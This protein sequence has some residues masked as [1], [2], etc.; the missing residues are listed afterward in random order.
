MPTTNA[1]TDAT[2]QNVGFDCFEADLQS[3]LLFKRGLKIPLREQ[4]FQVLACLLQHPAQVVSREELRRQLWPGDVFVDFEKSL[5]TAVAHLRQ[6]L[7]DSADRPRFIETVPKRGYRFLAGVR[8]LPENA[9]GPI[10]RRTR[11][12]VLPF[13]NWSG[14]AAEEYFSDAMTDE[15]ITALAALAPERLAVI[16]R[17]TAMRYKGTHKD[18]ARIGRELNVDYVV[19]GGVRRA[20]HRVAIN[21]QL[22]R[23]SDQTHVFA[24]KYDAEM[25][26]VFGLHDRVARDIGTQIPAAAG[27][28]PNDATLRGRARKPTEDLAAYNEYIQGRYFMSRWTPE[29]VAKARRHFEVALA[30]DPAF[31]LAYDAL[32]E[33]CW[34]LG[35]WGFASPTEMDLIGRGYALRAIEIDDTLAETHALLGYFPKAGYWDWEEVLQCV[36]RGRGLNPASPVVGLRYAIAL[37]VVGRAG[38]A[39]TELERALESDPL[40]LELRGWFAEA[41]YLGRQYDRA[42]EQALLLAESEPQHFLSHMVLGHVYLG[43]QRY[44]ESVA[45]LRKSADVSGGFPLVLGW[46]GL[47]LGL[48]GHSE[49]A[50]TVLERLRA[51]AKQSYVPPTS[52]AWTHLGLG[53]IDDALIWLDR[54]ADAHDRMANTLKTYPFLDPLRADP[55]FHALLRKMN[56]ES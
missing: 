4:S 30:R 19:E 5:N 11:L 46:L 10:T 24:R 49:E 48:G 14:D 9:T 32:A 41:L 35:F 40:S 55:R 45:A 52:F 47:A 6:A 56:L 17:T 29:G 16:A 18:V 31:A 42:I 33:L 43:P 28:A 51:I 2:R 8:V 27:N 26:D 44:E 34:Y 15:I 37:L 13:A 7:G 54:A 12:A 22:V 36:E 3:G 1:A 53:E 39:I 20:D 38:E 25:G 21:V 23:T 50:R